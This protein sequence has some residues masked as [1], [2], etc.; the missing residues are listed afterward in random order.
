[1]IRN[2]DVVNADCSRFGSRRKIALPNWSLTLARLLTIFILFT[3][4][5]LTF[6]PWQQTSQG[7]GKVIAFDPNYRVQK[8]SSNVKGRINKWLVRDGSH[9]KSGEPIVEIVDNDPQLIARL[10]IERD[11][12]FQK[13]QAAKA[14]TETSMLNLNRQEKLLKQG[15]TSQ[16]KFEKSRIDYKKLL[17]SE[18]TA[19]AN[20]AGAEVKLSRQQN[21]LVTAP[22][23]GTILNI[24]HGSG[25]IFVK[26]GDVLAAF[27][28]DSVKPAVE[29]FIDGND[30][31]LVYAG[32]H[33]R[34]QFEGWPAVQFAGW[35]SV[36]IGTFGGI[37]QNVDQSATKHGKFRVIIVP[38][39]IEGWPDQKF[40][41]QGARVYGWILLNNVRLGYE[42]WRQFNGFPAALD[43][44]P[45]DINR[46]K[47]K[48]QE[49]KEKENKKYKDLYEEK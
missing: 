2:N 9:V 21:Q 7:V 45:K 37:V 24:Y 8:I 4:L 27:V 49:T 28:P 26:E 14:A 11:A 42:V 10:K 13:Y 19:A 18:A 25:S 17:A 31:P 44:P 30:L 1:M 20:L 36:A 29:I 34:L 23:D 16:R 33:V 46:I 15:L 35:P 32:R 43:A 41:R 6:T 5:V 39:E 12:I 47:K 22:R 48:Y 40:L 38:D 3:F